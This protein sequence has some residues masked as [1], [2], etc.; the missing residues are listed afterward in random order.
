MTHRRT[1]MTVVGALVAL[2][3][4]A[5]SA[6]PGSAAVVGHDSISG[7]D[8]DAVAEALCAVQSGGTTGQ[9]L[10]SR[11]ARQGALDVM[12]NSELSR[13]Y[14]ESQG[15]T[16]DQRQVSAA[17][18]ANEQNINHLPAQ[19]RA[20]FR[21]TLRKYAEGQLMLIDIG[22]R[23][24]TA[25]GKSNVTDQD[26]VAQGTKMRD[27]WAAKN[28]HVS[29]DPRYGE[30][31]KGALQSKSGSLSVA[32]SQR[33]TDGDSPDPSAGWVNALPASQKCGA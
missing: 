20:I 27:A 28:A 25:Q 29:V 24:L 17:L 5:C 3:L 2:V 30:Y 10:A 18:A 1:L 13:Q 7:K 16:P 15:V 22:R 31:T 6:H 26:A 11:A 23:A 9:A 19:H 8:V 12:I 4:T 33:A 14:G 32:T 21:D